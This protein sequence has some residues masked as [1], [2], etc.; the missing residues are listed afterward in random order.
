M[1]LLLS[2]QEADALTVGSQNDVYVNRTGN[3]VLATKFGQWTPE[4]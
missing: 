3:V 1:A 4:G 2:A